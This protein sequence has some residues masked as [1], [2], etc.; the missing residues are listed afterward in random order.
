MKNQVQKIQTLNELIHSCDSYRKISAGKR[1]ILP[2]GDGMAIGFLSSSEIPLE[3]SI[4]LHHKIRAYNQDKSPTEEIGVLIGLASGPVFTVADL[5]NVQNIWG[6]G[7]ILARR[8]MDVDDN[9]HILIAEN[10][11]E[12]LLSLKDEYRHVIRLISNKYRIK[13][14]Q[15]IKLYTAYSDDFGNQQIPAKVVINK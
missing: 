1:I 14:G 9:G 12:M 7:I 5:N 8:V 15:K 11:A 3:L 10:L 2:T 4:Q 6:P 13:H